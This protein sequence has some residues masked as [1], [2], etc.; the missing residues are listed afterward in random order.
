VVE[1]S[2]TRDGTDHSSVQRRIEAV[3]GQLDAGSVELHFDADTETCNIVPV[4]GGPPADS[5]AK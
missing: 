2:V 3:L 5:W 1:E 4:E